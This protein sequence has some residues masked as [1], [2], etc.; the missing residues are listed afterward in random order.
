MFRVFRATGNNIK[1]ETNYIFQNQ[2]TYLESLAKSFYDFG[3]GSF[4]FYTRFMP[5]LQ[6]QS[7]YVISHM[8]KRRW[9]NGNQ[10]G[11]GFSHDSASG[12]VVFRN[13]DGV[14]A[15]L[16]RLR[17]SMGAANNIKGQRVNSIALIRS[18]TNELE[19]V[20]NSSFR[21][22]KDG[23]QYPFAKNASGATPNGNM[24]NAW[25][26]MIGASV[27][28]S[29]GTIS[30]Y[31]N[32]G[33][34]GLTVVSD[35]ALSAAQI[36]ALDNNIIPTVGSRG[37]WVMN[38]SPVKDRSSAAN[39]LTLNS[40][41]PGDRNFIKEGAVVF[42][43]PTLGV[44]SNRFT[45]NRQLTI[46]KLGARGWANGFQ[47]TYSHIRNGIVIASTTPAFTSGTGTAAVNIQMQ[48]GDYLEWVATSGHGT[49][50]CAIEHY[51]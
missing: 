26:F 46:T 41:V 24:T 23:V 16:L 12:E 40:S 28:S 36:N 10:I 8:T 22:Y 18:S 3:Y 9:S 32:Q 5:L 2:A 6:G 21:F 37:I 39:D 50:G 30:N 48:P 4:S 44:P 33:Y 20:D 49:N 34:I 27:S 13:E 43:H 45:A 35:V 25:P 17:S 1:V 29:T 19:S 31:S 51:Y 38:G 15:N 14:S 47:A 11:Y 42:F 7:G